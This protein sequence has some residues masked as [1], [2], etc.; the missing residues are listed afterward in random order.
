M[1]WAEKLCHKIVD[2]LRRDW[3]FWHKP[4]PKWLIGLGTRIGLIVF[5]MLKVAGQAYIE[6]LQAKI[7]ETKDKYP[8]ASDIEKLKI[9]VDF[10]KT[11]LPAWK[12]NRLYGLVTELYMDMK[13]LKMV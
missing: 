8:T 12:D 9:V 1:N 10:A 13:D 11:L 4:V 2:K 5:N 3:G 7:I 6:K